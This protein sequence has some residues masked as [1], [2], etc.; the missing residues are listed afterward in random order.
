MYVSGCIIAVVSEHF[1]D[2]INDVITRL[3][4]AETLLYLLWEF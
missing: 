1:A 3:V 2:V 4:R